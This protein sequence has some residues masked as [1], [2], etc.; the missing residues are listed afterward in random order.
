LILGKNPRFVKKAGALLFGSISN[1]RKLYFPAKD[2]LHP[3]R[4]SW[5]RFPEE[6]LFS[7]EKGALPSGG[8]CRGKSDAPAAIFRRDF[9][10]K[11]RIRKQRRKKEF[12]LSGKT[13]Q[14]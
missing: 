10:P 14:G 1:S 8:F 2:F 6:A 7:K 12:S 3:E 11:K 5:P 13:G 4:P 9:F